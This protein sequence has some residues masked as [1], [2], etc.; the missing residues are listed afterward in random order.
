MTNVKTSTIVGTQL[1]DFVRNDYPVFVTFLEKYYEWLETQQ[2]VSS[3]INQLQL[4]K[5]IDEANEYYLDKLKNDLLPYFP[6]EVVSDKRLFLKLVTQFYKS[7]G[8]QDSIKFLF[9]AL[10]NENIDIYYPKDEIL[11]AS[12]GKWVLPLALRVDTNDLNIFNIENTLIVGQTSKATAIVEKVTQSVDRQLGITYIELYV[13]NV[14]R[15]FD[16]GETIVANYIDPIT[17]L[18]VTVN[19][20]LIGSLSEIKID[21]RFRGA[22]YTGGTFTSAGFVEGDPV[23]IVGGLNPLANNPIGAIA[24]V[25]ETTSGGVENLFITDGGFGFRNPLDDLYADTPTSIVDFKG[26]FIDASSLG[27]E[28]KATVSL[29]DTSNTRNVNVSTMTVSL[30]DGA[31]ITIAAIE[32]STVQNVSTYSEFSVH[33]IS[34]VLLDTGGGGYR[35]KPTIKTYSLY[36]EDFSDSLII[37]SAIALKGSRII[38]DNTPGQDFTVD[39]ERGDYVRLFVQNKFEEVREVSDVTAN[40]LFFNETFPVDIGFGGAQGI[41]EVY[42]INRNDLYKI[43]SLGRIRV[44]NGGTGYQN[45]DSIIFTGGSGYGANGYVNV[46]AGIITSATINVHSTGAYVIGGEGYTNESLPT[47][48]VQSTSGQ[49]AVLVVSEVT[50]SGDEY[51]LSTSRIGAITTL[52]ITSFG[53]DYVSAPIISLRNAD[54]LLSN[55]TEG[56]LFVSNTVVYQGTSNT[57]FTFRAFVDNYDDATLTLRIFN[58]IGTLN[59]D[60]IIKYDSESAIA[61]VTA[62]V[63]TSVFYGDGNARA[64]A[65]FENGLIRYPG[66]YLNTDG[67]PSSDKRLQDGIKYH[68]F[69]YVIKSSTDYAKFKKPLN[70]IVHPLGTKTFT[71]R[72][73]DNNENITIANTLSYVT[74]DDL[75]NTYN[76]MFNTTKIISTSATANLVSIVNVGDVIIVDS[77]RRGISNTV[78]VVSGSNVMFGNANSVNFINDLQ[79][80]DT[81]LLSTGNTATVREVVNVSHAILSTTINV[82]STSATINVI[83]PEVVR[84]NTVNANT[85]FTTTQIRGNGNNLLARIEKVR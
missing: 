66:I 62:N 21:P 2:N 75:P 45:G 71:Y 46:S 36:N 63:V 15:L 68:N 5:D 77:V 18:N 33:P 25:G 65:K 8:T 50:G 10:F 55:V 49:G 61:A 35:Q 78:N 79:D 73:D 42:K 40:T 12:D 31:T 34:F 51:Q 64:T 72:M 54:L 7:S 39:V 19:S 41:L 67:Q 3:G 9:R 47:L 52:K 81:I 37:S 60:I 32:T 85:I 53:Y 48:S 56:Q 14:K 26:G 4:S 24:F 80:G 11:I 6:Q 16:T 22:F 83:Y 74:I 57:N 30:L 44:V 13:S 59:R 82:T 20:R 29:V 23:T 76:V 1:P 17:N 27:Q 38:V 70:D 69:S 43:G 28:A 58:Y 84:V